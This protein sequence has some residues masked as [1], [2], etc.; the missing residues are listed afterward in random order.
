M[1]IQSGH[2][3]TDDGNDSDFYD[4]EE[5]NNIDKSVNYVGL[6][7]NPDTCAPFFFNK[8][9]HVVLKVYL[10]LSRKNMRI[11]SSNENTPNRGFATT[12]VQWCMAGR[13]TNG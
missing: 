10:A 6:K 13:T 12:S 3:D 11:L 9:I 2:C 7:C 5:S 1:K 4:V 8:G